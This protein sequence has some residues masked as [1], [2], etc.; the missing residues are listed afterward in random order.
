MKVSPPMFAVADLWLPWMGATVIAALSMS[1]FVF[2]NFE[3]KED[4]K[5]KNQSL[6]RNLVDR[7]ERLEKR[8]D[9][10]EDKID[11]MLKSKAR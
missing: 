2:K 11:L 8:L 3:T 1:A 4:A 9:R 7:S 5:D 10:I 6:E